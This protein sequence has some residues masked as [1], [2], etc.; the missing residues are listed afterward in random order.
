VPAELVVQRRGTLDTEPRAFILQPVGG[1]SEV[2]RHMSRLCAD[3]RSRSC[4]EKGIDDHATDGREWNPDAH[5]TPRRDGRPP[6]M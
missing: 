6:P 5:L 2:T 3:S 1:G 4:N